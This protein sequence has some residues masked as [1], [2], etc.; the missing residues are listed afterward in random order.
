MCV[1]RGTSQAEEAA[2][3]LDA[4]AGG[5]H[6]SQHPVDGKDNCGEGKE[7]AGRRRRRAD[8]QLRYLG[9]RYR[10]RPAPVT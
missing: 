9:L 8:G 2:E 4:K 5:N 7:Q 1:E 6:A 3:R 10:H